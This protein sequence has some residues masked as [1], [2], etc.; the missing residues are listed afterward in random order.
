MSSVIDQ[1][2]RSPGRRPSRGLPPI[3]TWWTL[4]D[5]GLQREI[6]ADPG[7]PLRPF[8]VRRVF[9]ICGFDVESA[10]TASLTLGANERAYIAGW[11]HA[12]DWT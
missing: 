4:L 6:L 5:R 7:A 8:V 9:E 10:P 1:P 11:S 12:V 3:G 2:S